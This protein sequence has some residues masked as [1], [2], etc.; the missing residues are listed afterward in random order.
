MLDCLFCCDS[1]KREIKQ[2]SK[3]S[4]NPSEDS[5][6]IDQLQPVKKS[7]DLPFFSEQKEN[8]GKQMIL[9]IDGEEMIR[10]ILRT[11]FWEDHYV[12]IFLRTWEELL[13]FLKTSELLPD[14]VLINIT[15]GDLTDFKAFLTALRRD[16]N[17]RMLPIITMIPIQMEPEI[18]SVLKAGVNDYVIR[19]LKRIEV[20]RKIGVHIAVRNNAR[21]KKEADSYYRILNDVFPRHIISEMEKNQGTVI[22][23]PHNFISVLFSD[24]VDFT[25]L[26][27][28]VNINHI[29]SMLN[30]MFS[31]FDEIC[32]KHDAY[33]VETIGDA[34]MIVCGHDNKHEHIHAQILMKVAFE[35]L[36]A[37]AVMSPVDGKQIQIRIGIHSGPAYSGVIGKS[38]PRYCFFG[39]TVNT[40][41]RMESNGMPGRVHMSEA[42][43][44]L[45]RSEPG[46]LFSKVDMHYIKGKGL[47]TTYF[48]EKA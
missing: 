33:K 9:C 5:L 43:Y 12:V 13:V 30:D 27:A 28:E 21:S 2:C 35:M 41:N 22:V 32:A 37:V 24:I 29:V 1:V 15:T 10:N 40:A 17:S 26:S 25:C 46:Y 39:D 42:T 19:P 36:D 18:A 38:R 16:F 34:Y 44:E 23:E 4:H 3:P 14:I 6:D 31:R 48:V 20:I 11:I 47:M 45:V 8:E 7:L